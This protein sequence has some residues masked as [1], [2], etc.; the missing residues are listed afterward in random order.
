[1]TATFEMTGD[2]P[3]GQSPKQARRASTL[4]PSRDYMKA[5]AP[6]HKIVENEDDVFSSSKD[7]DEFSSTS[8]EASVSGSASPCSHTHHKKSPTNK[9]PYVQIRKDRNTSLSFT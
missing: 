4:K 3:S 8:N 5:I 9:S 1:M 6:M 2:S 7:T